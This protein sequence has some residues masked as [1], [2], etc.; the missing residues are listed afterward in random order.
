MIPSNA[1]IWRN[2]K[3]YII[4]TFGLMMYAFAW[5]GI[6]TPADIIGGG[7]SGASLL[8][9]YAT[10]GDA[11]GGIPMGYTYFVINAIL[12]VL[13]TVLVGAKLGTKTIYAI[14]AVS[15]FL[16]V[17][18]K[19]IPPDFVGL[20]SD[21]LLSAILGGVIAGAGVSLCFAQGGNTG[22]TDIVAVLV[23]KYRAVSYGRVLMMCD[24]VIIGSS[25]FV[26]DSVAIVVYG[27]IMVGS[28][29]YVVDMITGGNKQSSQIFII[30]KNPT[31]IADKIFDQIQR[32]VTLIDGQGWYSKE[33]MK[34]VMVVCR[35]NETPSLFR[36]IKEVDPDAFITM[37]SV[38]GVYGLG[39]ETLRIKKRFI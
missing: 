19:V 23:N 39:F 38:M 25:F 16:S 1:V 10:G 29:G 18:Q 26:V 8:L 6:I 37:A 28:M 20:A 13:V 21:K 5:V 27:Y 7:V 22:G 35:K 2:F 30:S 14:F 36:L 32:G 9:Y 4:I 17:G 34:I 24:F 31:A 12:V 3:E 15:L 11:G 33:P